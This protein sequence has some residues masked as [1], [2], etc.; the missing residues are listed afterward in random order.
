MKSRSQST[1]V[2]GPWIEI[3]YDEPDFV[4]RNIYRMYGGW[5]NG[6]P[7][8]LKPA[9]ESELAL[10]TCE[11]RWFRGKADRQGT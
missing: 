3:L 5:W 11:A 4:V 1:Y 2:T 9:P 6:N 7:A 10:E 8:V